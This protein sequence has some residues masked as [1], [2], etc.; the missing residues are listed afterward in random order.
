MQLSAFSTTTK[1]WKKGRKNNFLINTYEKN[2]V[3]K[4][5]FKNASDFESRFS[6]RVN[7]LVNFTQLVIFWISVFTACQVLN[8]LHQT[9]YIL[10]IFELNF[11]IAS[12]LESR[13]LQRIRFQWTTV[14]RKSK[15]FV[16]R[17]FKESFSW[18]IYTFKTSKL[19][20]C[21]FLK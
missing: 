7:L 13:F 17:A 5:V 2:R 20:F 3:L 18:S 8:F 10:S 6:K 16:K 1:C 12:E 9:F 11:H 19:V 14:F 4:Q 21:A 15:S